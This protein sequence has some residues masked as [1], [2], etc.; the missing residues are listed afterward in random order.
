MAGQIAG[1]RNIV[2]I[3]LISA[4]LLVLALFFANRVRIVKETK[5]ALDMS[6]QNLGQVLKNRRLF[7]FLF[8]VLFVSIGMNGILTFY[9]VY[10]TEIGATRKLIGWAISLQGF[11]ELP[12]YLVSAVILLRFGMLRTIIFTF[13]VL[14]VR[15]MLY[16]TISTPGYVIFVELTHGMSLALLIVSSV[17]YINKLVPAQWRATGQSLFWAAIF[18]AGSLF[19]NLGVGYLYDR[20]SMQN[21]FQVFGWFLLGA[22]V[23]A[24][25]FLREKKEPVAAEPVA[26]DK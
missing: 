22:A 18:G 13:F 8:F 24:V 25:I 1:E 7:L 3:F 12:F 16:A 9:G 2:A 20:M 26:L 5:G 6:W 11:S 19:G 17:E 14:A 21:V 15:A 23:L 10:M 4:V